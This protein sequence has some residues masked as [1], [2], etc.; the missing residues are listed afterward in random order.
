MAIEGASVDIKNSRIGRSDKGVVLY[1]GELRLTDSRIRATTVGVAAASGSAVIVN[2]VF[3]S[4]REV[5]YA[6][7]RANVQARGNRV[8]S[9]YVCRPQFRDRYRGRYE[10]YWRP[11]DGWECA[12]G[13]YPRNW[14]ANEDGLLG[15]EYYDDGYSL[16]GYDRY[17]RGEGWYDRDG[18]YV[19]DERYRGEDRWSRGGGGFWGR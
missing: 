8:Y 3:S 14:W 18:R 5:I 12:F 10:P 2:N 11:G 9:Q 7:D 1:N 17:Q 15:L 19:Y 16:D 6:E 4:V 13:S